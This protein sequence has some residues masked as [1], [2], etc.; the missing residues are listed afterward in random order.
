MHSVGM[1]HYKHGGPV[2]DFLP[3][4]DDASLYIL[5]STFECFMKGYSRCVLRTERLRDSRGLWDG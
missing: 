5:Q 4:E 1:G 3:L 2:I